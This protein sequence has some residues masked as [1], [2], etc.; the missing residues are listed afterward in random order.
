MP[1]LGWLLAFGALAALGLPGL[2][3]FW[4]ELLAIGGAW[5]SAALG[6]LGRPLAVLAAVGTAVAA[7]YLLR[8]L[9]LIW[10]GPAP[11]RRRGAVPPPVTAGDAT[12]HELAVTAPLVVAVAALGV[13]P[14]L[15]LNVT[16]RPSARCSA[17]PAVTRRRLSRPLRARRDTV[18]ALPGVQALDAL[19]VAPVAAP[20]VALLL[21]LVVDAVAPAAGRA[22]HLHDALALAGL[23]AAGAAV[24]AL[25]AD[26]ADRRTACVPGG[27]LQ[28][29]A[30]SYV[31]SPLT[32]ALQGVTR[33][34]RW[35]AC[36]WPSTGR[37]R[38]TGR[39]TTCCS[40]PPSP[41]PPRSRAR[42]TSR[43]SWSR[44][45]PPRCP[46]SGWWP[47]DATREAQGAVTFLLTA[48]SSLGLLLLGSAL[49]LAATGSAHFDRIATALGDPSLPPRVRAVAVLGV[50]LA[51]AGVAF[52]LSAVP[53]HL[54]TPDTYAGAPLPVAAFL[55]TVSKAAATA[56]FVVLLVVG[57]APLA[58]SWAPVLGLVAAVTI[59]VG[60]LV[61]LRQ[62]VAVRLLAW[63]TVAQA[64]WVLLPLAGAGDG[65][66]AQLRAAATGSVGYLAA[67]VAATL[68]VFAVVVLLA[69]HHRAGEEHRL[70]DYRGLARRE[71]VA[72]AV[73]AFGLPAWPASRPVSWGWSP[74]CWRS[75]PS[76][77][78]PRGRS[79]WWR[80]RTWRWGSSTTCAGV[81]CCSPGR[82]TARGSAPSPPGGSGRP[83]GW[84]SA[85][86][87]PPASYSP[88]GRR[89]SP[90]SCRGCCDEVCVGREPPR[91]DLALTRYGHRPRRTKEPTTPWVTVIST[92]SRPP[93]CWG[94]C[95]PSCCSWAG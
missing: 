45:R 13:L 35:C 58:A 52:K 93:C 2:A 38:G 10:H 77:T 43:P 31:I 62:R 71:P 88:S 5:R 75:G 36:C 17:A 40:S 4:G 78:W 32:L 79:P 9:R 46:P 92:D 21:V 69:R 14:W 20:L 82:R 85:R 66:P 6:P 19:A 76:S 33:P 15:L 27:G 39:R 11:A 22:R 3:G 65:G 51:V 28:L 44:S 18:N 34:R 68:A 48:L 74:R 42:A 50:L 63:S 87:G 29:S 57:V 59:T 83:R 91:S 70:E 41:G 86:P 80:P 8:M 60:N 49:V 56:A 24:V 54:W 90:G 30:C 61:A 81:P 47:C 55:A 72:A 94:A 23:L 64:G 16:G 84:R 25:A 1:R 89:R 73:L 12:P 53:F 37:G 7:A 67:Y 26:G 95:P